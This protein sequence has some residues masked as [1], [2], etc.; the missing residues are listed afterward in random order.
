MV[1]L[2]ALEHLKADYTEVWTASQNVPLVRFADRV[3]SIVSTGIDGFPPR[4]KALEPFDE[5]VSW[6]GTNRP[7]FREAVR[8]YPV[9][10]LDALPPPS[11][12]HAV[13]FYL[14]QVGAADGQ[15][16]R[17]DC[18]RRDSGFV[19]IHPFSGSARK[20]WPWFGELASQ[21]PQEARFCVS[22]EQSWPGG[23]Q[24]ENLYELAQWIATSSLYIGN[25][26]GVTHLAAAV[27]VP[28]IAVFQAS[29]PAVWAPRS[30]ATV[31][32]LQGPSVSDVLATVRTRLPSR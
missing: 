29:D 7:E 6:Y 8:A 9:K 1:S 14:R 12:G 18:E 15:V 28:V 32:V 10:F 21:L 26:S 11:G 22:P 3:R 19:A 24:F 25:D 17:L 30:T 27:G 5:V 23:V 13:D 16:P 31:D 4:T 2:P 20:N